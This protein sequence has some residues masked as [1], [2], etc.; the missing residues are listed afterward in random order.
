MN[1]DKKWK[2]ETMLAK[3]V[4]TGSNPG[5]LL[6]YLMDSDKDQVSIDIIFFI[7]ITII[8]C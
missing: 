5:C 6:G 4:A 7:K 2:V 1:K 8:F 3:V